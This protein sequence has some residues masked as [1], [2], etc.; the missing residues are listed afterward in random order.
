MYR[1]ADRDPGAGVGLA[2]DLTA[3]SHGPGALLNAV[4]SGEI[5][6]ALLDDKVKRILRLYIRSG[7][8]NPDQRGKG[9]LD[10]PAH[11]EA[12]RTLAVGRLDRRVPLA[13]EVAD[14]HFA[15]DRLVVDDENGGHVE[16]SKRVEG[17]RVP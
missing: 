14:D 11:R 2:D 8:L 10:S 16:V 4:K 5:P 15:H 6:A 3:A 1:Q 13:F 12:A 9:E 17:L 7:V